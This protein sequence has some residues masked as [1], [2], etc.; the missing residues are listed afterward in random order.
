MKNTALYDLLG[1]G[2]NISMM[3]ML[4]GLFEK[5]IKTYYLGKKENSEGSVSLDISALDVW[6]D[7][8][9]ISEWGGMTSFASRASDIVAKY[10]LITN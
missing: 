6:D 7:N 2:D 5:K 1:V 3:R 9:I 10:S 4:E 8:P